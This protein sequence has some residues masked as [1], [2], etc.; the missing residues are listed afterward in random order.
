VPLSFER[1]VGLS[2]KFARSV[3]ISRNNQRAGGPA[4]KFVEGFAGEKNSNFCIPPELASVYVRRCRSLS[5]A[6]D[7]M[8]NQTDGLID[9]GGFTVKEF[10]ARYKISRTTFYEEL[11]AKRLRAKKVGSKTIVLFDDARAWAK[12]LPNA[13]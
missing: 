13:A 11:N 6:G 2:R 7:N 1:V 9:D 4:L 5:A 10:C 8:D 12:S 3:N